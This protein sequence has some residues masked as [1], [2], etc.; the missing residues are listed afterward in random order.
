MQHAGEK[1]KVSSYQP[2][3]EL[4]FA[5]YLSLLLQ[6]FT[7]LQI[8]AS[9]YLESVGISEPVAK[10]LLATIIF[11]STLIIDISHMVGKKELGQTFCPKR[12]DGT[13][14]NISSQLL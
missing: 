9:Y 10:Y 1:I 7:Y 3:H 8:I 4:N 2:E 6:I 11:F 13:R 5:A 14:R 12:H